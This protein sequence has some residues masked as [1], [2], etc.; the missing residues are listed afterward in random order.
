MGTTIGGTKVENFASKD[1]AK[2][3]F[4]DLYLEKTGNEWSERHNFQKVGQP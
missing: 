2:Q 4:K 3:L 1:A